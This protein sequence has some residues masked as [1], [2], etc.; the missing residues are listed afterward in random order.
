MIAYDG[1]LQDNIAIAFAAL[2]YKGLKEG[3]RLKEA[4]EW[5]KTVEDVAC[6]HADEFKKYAFVTPTGEAD[7]KRRLFEARKNVGTPES[8]QREIDDQYDL[9]RELAKKGYQGSSLREQMTLRDYQKE[10][11]KVCAQ[12][13]SS[14]VVMP[15]GSGKSGVAFAL[16]KDCAKKY[17]G[18]KVAF[19]TKSVALMFQQARAF[20]SFDVPADEVGRYCGEAYN[21]R[22]DRYAEK[23]FV[24]FTAGLFRYMLDNSVFDISDF[25]LLVMDEAHNCKGNDDY[26]CILREY[27]W[28]TEAKYRPRIVGLSA[29]PAD[30]KELQEKIIRLCAKLGNAELATPV[31]HEQSMLRICR[32]PT[33]ETR[34]FEI[35]ENARH[36]DDVVLSYL[37]QLSELFARLEPSVKARLS[38][39]T[40][41][42]MFD[43]LLS[44]PRP[45]GTTE[46]GGLIYDHLIEV[47]EAYEQYAEFGEDA[48]LTTIRDCRRRFEQRV[49]KKTLTPDTRAR[50]FAIFDDS[51][52]TEDI[53][54]L[55]GSSKDKFS[56]LKQLLLEELREYDVNDRTLIFVK[57]RGTCK[58]LS[59][60]INSLLQTWYDTGQLKHKRRCDYVVGRGSPGSG[61]SGSSGS[62]PGMS[63]Q[64]L[65]DRVQ[66][67]REGDV[68]V[69]VATS[70]LEEGIDVGRCR[71]VVRYDK[72]QTATALQQSRGRARAEGGKTILLTDDKTEL[73]NFLAAERQL[74]EATQ[75]A[76]ACIEDGLGSTAKRFF[77]LKDAKTMLERYC[78]TVVCTTELP[79]YTTTRASTECA[80]VQQRFISTV[81]MPRA[82]VEKH[83][84][85]AEWP[86]SESHATRQAAEDKAAYEVA[87]YLNDRGLI[88]DLMPGL[89]F[90]ARVAQRRDDPQPLEEPPTRRSQDSSQSDASVPT[91]G[92]PAPIDRDNLRRALQ[93][94]VSRSRD[95][96]THTYG[97]KLNE[98]NQL[99]PEL[100]LKLEVYGVNGKFESVVR[101]ANGDAIGAPAE[102]TTK[103]RS[104]ELA[105]SNAIQALMEETNQVG[106]SIAE[107]RA[108]LA[109]HH[110]L[111]P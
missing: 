86:C 3:S 85:K 93:V 39:N 101:S 40:L 54:G 7:L 79:T 27:Y 104:R 92:A 72:A 41:S 2:V 45:R 46:R 47:L 31:T 12:T 61:T 95:T 66:R 87:V 96:P 69:L 88:S 50:L 68:H 20:L 108:F 32:A 48:A 77:V 24:F 30:G 42:A 15:T 29:T 65:V 62:V 9:D 90:L 105:A 59:G 70:V 43:D 22:R 56:T 111:T 4:F 55:G 58:K 28:T 10:V 1:E 73:D 52:E 53:A 81:S 89:N 110:I 100:G 16:M 67:F 13:K 75:L 78:S 35:H 109:P 98:L 25:S 91:R 18:R 83:G 23:P 49:L 26:A 6:P 84:I 102:A 57:T 107:R 106:G 82:C 80:V 11:L 5:A 19:L 63:V 51:A 76:K 33:L 44:N 71:L 60:I 74:Q 34:S 38:T 103:K 97:M 37:T 14:L 21:M 64:D 8:R 36:V 99:L 94:V 17:W